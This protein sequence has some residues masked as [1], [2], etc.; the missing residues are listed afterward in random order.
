MA[1]FNPELWTHAL[2]VG[3]IYVQ[4]GINN[5]DDWSA[6]MTESCGTKIEP[7][8][9]SIWETINNLPEGTKFDEEQVM[10]ISRVVGG[11]RRESK[12][13]SLGCVHTIEL[14]KINE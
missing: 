1:S 14:R 12:A 4:R 6:K 5:F 3:A 7:W 10:A 2:A 9:S 13:K 11:L 8:L